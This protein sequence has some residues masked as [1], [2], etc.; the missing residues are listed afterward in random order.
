MTPLDN[1]KLKFQGWSMSKISFI[2]LIEAFIEHKTFFWWNIETILIYLQTDLLLLSQQWF[3]QTG[4]REENKS[5]W[6]QNYGLQLRLLS[7]KPMPAPNREISI[8]NHDTV[9]SL[10]K[11]V[12][13]RNKSREKKS[14]ITMFYFGNKIRVFQ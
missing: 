8:S 13:F 6:R 9:S 7:L 1:P 12:E 10:W 14:L 2:Q 11:T 3:N 5:N 4:Q